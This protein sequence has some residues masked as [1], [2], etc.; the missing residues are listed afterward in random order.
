MAV[1]EYCRTF[2][3]VKGTAGQLIGSFK[4]PEL[5]THMEQKLAF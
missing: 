2:D 3:H 4:S 5:K 1:N